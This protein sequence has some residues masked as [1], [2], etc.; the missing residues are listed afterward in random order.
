IDANISTARRW[1]C[2]IDTRAKCHACGQG[3]DLVHVFDSSGDNTF[4]EEQKAAADEHR[5]FCPIRGVEGWRTDIAQTYLVGDYRDQ[6]VDASNRGDDIMSLVGEDY[7][8]EFIQPRLSHARITTSQRYFNR[9]ALAAQILLKHCPKCLRASST[10]LMGKRMHERVCQLTRFDWVTLAEVQPL[11]TQEGVDGREMIMNSNGSLEGRFRALTPGEKVRLERKYQLQLYTRMNMDEKTLTLLG[12]DNDSEDVPSDQDDSL[13]PRRRGPRR[14]RPHRRPIHSDNSD[15][16]NDYGP[17]R[18]GGR[19]ARRRVPTLEEYNSWHDAMAPTIL[20]GDN[21]STEKILSKFQMEFQEMLQ[22][23]NPLATGVPPPQASLQ[24]ATRLARKSNSAREGLNT[25][26][27]TTG[28]GRIAPPRTN[29]RASPEADRE[30]PII[31]DPTPTLQRAYDLIPAALVS[32][33]EGTGLLNSRLAFSWRVTTLRLLLPAWRAQND[34]VRK[35]KRVIGAAVQKTRTGLQMYIDF[36][37]NGGLITTGA[38][39]LSFLEILSYPDARLESDH[40]SIQ[41]LFPTDS[42]SQSN[43]LAPPMPDGF[44]G[45]MGSARFT[46]CF[47]L[48]MRRIMAFWGFEFRGTSS[49]GRPLWRLVPSFVAANHAWTR[50]VDHNHLRVTR[51]IRCLRLAGAPRGA[52]S[53]YRSIIRA[54]RERNLPVNERSRRLWRRAALGPLN[55]DPLSSEFPPDG[56]FRTDSEPEEA[57]DSSDIYP[58]N[59]DGNNDDDQEGVEGGAGPPPATDPKTRTTGDRPAPPHKRQHYDNRGSGEGLYA[60]DNSSSSEGFLDP[61]ERDGDFVPRRFPSSPIDDVAVPAIQPQETQKTAKSKQ[62]PFDPRP[63][64]RIG[65]KYIPPPTRKSKAPDNF[66][67]VER[68][69]IT[70]AEQARLEKIRAAALE[71]LNPDTTR[72]AKAV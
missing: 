12:D 56:D 8:D 42:V 4:P 40:S 20:G 65:R 35:R 3:F 62:T 49:T 68:R 26:R 11:R 5:T 23:N 45:A 33:L 31:T 21:D 46:G 24:R 50:R 72:P 59:L 9:K 47:M 64:P 19:I 54:I 34:E 16:E 6:F 60:A 48:G 25:A 71:E 43:A 13:I 32:A 29:I 28:R 53:V 52:R 2:T 22:Q 67:R 7:Y 39:S 66:R 17:G 70:P 14:R 57:E 55:M 30:R 38:R 61:H 10:T 18:G 27:K 44:R 41:L 36:F 63:K 15:D 37:T 69:K 51:L 58:G 1:F